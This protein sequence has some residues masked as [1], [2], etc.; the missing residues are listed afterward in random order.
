MFGAGAKTAVDTLI[1]AIGAERA[2]HEQIRRRFIDLEKLFGETRETLSVSNAVIKQQER[3]I[4]AVRSL[5]SSTDS[6]LWLR[7]PIDKPQNYE[8]KLRNSIPIIV[9]AN[10]KGGVA[11]TTLSANIAAYFELEKNER[12]LVIDLDFQGSLTSMLRSVS[13]KTPTSYANSAKSVLTPGFDPS[14]LLHFAP[15]IR[16]STR[17]SRFINCGQE[18]ANH[19]VALLLSWVIGDV[20]EDIRYLL[21]KVL[22][23]EAVQDNFDR[24]IIDAPPRITTSFVNALCASTHLL[25]P[26]VLDQLSTDGVS[27]FLNDFDKLHP[28]LFPLLKLTGVL[29]TMK[30]TQTD[31]LEQSEQAAIETLKK[32]LDRRV[33]YEECF[34]SDQ[35]MPRMEAF[36]RAAGVRVAYPERTVA[37]TINSLG[38]KISEKAP[39]RKVN[40]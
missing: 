6:E 8:S 27:T 4:S 18:F 19:E 23:S 20:T 14:N 31:N 16:D 9:F 22:L 26:T 25:I 1:G 17:D 5:C 2:S 29:G 40:A 24:V 7:T 28:S 15:Q 12:V 32:L 3:T 37:P 13:E 36:A 38:I 11:K 35:L 33:G 39:N 21:A 10:L 30:R 34:W